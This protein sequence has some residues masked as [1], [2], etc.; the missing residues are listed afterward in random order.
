MRIR[1]TIRMRLALSYSLLFLLTG[2]A[3]LGVAH[4]MVRNSLV[5]EEGTTERRVV[6]S[7][8]YKPEDVEAFYG[9]RIP[10]PNELAGTS[11]GTEQ[12]TIGDVILGV[13][14]EIRR[15][16][17]DRLL[18]GTSIALLGLL[19]AAML[20]GWIMAGRVLAPIQRLT[21]AARRISESSLH[22]RIGL[23]GPQDE[24]R[25][26]ADTLD[27]MIS[28]LE[29]AFHSQRRFAADVS[30]ELRTP[31]AI[32]RA[33]ADVAIADDAASDREKA[34]GRRV[35]DAADR[36]ER[37]I[38]SLLALSR[39]E[40]SLQ[41]HD[42]IDLAEIA[43]D[44]L[45]A[46]TTAADRAGVSLDLD[47]QTAEVEGDRWLLERLVANL[48]DNGIAYNVRDGWLRVSVHRQNGHSVVTVANSGPSLSPEAAHRLFEPFHRGS[49]N[50]ASMPAGFGLGLTIVRAV[51]HAHGGEVGLQARE[52]GGLEVTVELPSST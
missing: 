17:L 48:V 39:G 35:R 24:L 32:I 11:R 45:G 40:S 19:V 12:L 21:V 47:L 23:S 28:R 13:Q 18:L 46:R 20:F 2:G 27:E 51:T 41:A 10:T 16:A 1:S 22:E 9:L 7:Y 31:V 49:S 42:T 6:E 52:G 5:S 3:L 43:G 8:G 44:V 34:L 36:C 37:L 4:T 38:D 50:G 14:Q 30:H 15:D 33:E 29:Q 26:L 25:E